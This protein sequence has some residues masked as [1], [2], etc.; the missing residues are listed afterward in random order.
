MQRLDSHL[1]GRHFLGIPGP[2]PVPDRILRAISYPTID[3][4][5][6]EFAELGK[7]VLEGMRGLFQTSQPVIIYPAS[8]TGAWEAAMV[9]TLSA[10]DHVLMYETGQFA[11]LWE[12]LAKKIGLQPEMLG[13]GTKGWRMGVDASAIEER[14]RADR[15]GRIKAVCVVHNETS[16]GAMSDIAAVRR[17]IDA[18]SHPALLIVD[19]I[20]GLGCAPYRHDAWGVD[21]SIAGSQ[22]GLMLPPG[23]GFNAIS[24]KARAA[25]AKA[26]LPRAYWSWD[27][28]LTMNATGYWPSTPN[29]NLLYGLSE[30]IDMMNEEGLPAIF[31][32]HE[33]LALACRK[34][35]GAWG[36]EL[37][38]LEAKSYSPVLSAVVMPEG[39]DA[40][41]VRKVILERFDLSLGA[42]LGPIK[43]RVFRIGHLGDC[44]ELTLVAVLA[45]CEMG[46][47]LS[48]VQLKS[49]GVV[50]AMASLANKDSSD[51]RQAA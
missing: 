40:D 49:S 12:G 11:S 36:L 20:S 6:P 2:S 37:Q 50:A 4:R 38:C 33:R 32:R 27:E 28:M 3:H 15:E 22:K 31:A 47:Q 9:N 43:G 7:K 39:I 29:T 35:I 19:T 25:S 48:G 23:L 14:L 21:V 44:N 46:L 17:A 34:A 51:Q 24:E 18:A 41:R 42:G 1:S 13:G 26:T 8:G 30:V 16:T 5:G 45:G 10:G